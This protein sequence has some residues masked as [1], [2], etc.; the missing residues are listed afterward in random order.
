MVLSGGEK[1]R[2]YFTS[3][4]YSRFFYFADKLIDHNI[5]HDIR[6]DN[7]ARGHTKEGENAC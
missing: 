5:K 2:G 1:R 6:L 4:Y 7:K 3:G